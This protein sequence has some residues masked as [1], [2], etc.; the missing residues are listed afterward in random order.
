MQDSPKNFIFIGRS[1]CGKGTQAELLIN[2]LKENDSPDRGIFYMEIGK[3]FRDYLNEQTYTTGLS[4]E[5]YKKG[6]LQPD[7]LAIH[8]W[9]HSII[10]DYNGSDHMIVD[11]IPRSL[12][13][14]EVFETAMNFYDK[15]EVFVIN[16]DVSEDWSRARLE[17]R[18]RADD[19][20]K[21]EV[22]NRLAWF[23][24][25]VIPAIDYFRKNSRY[26]VLDI[27]GEQSIEEVFAEILNK[28]SI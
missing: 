4:K 24:R 10:A 14:A 16:L 12:I 27:N 7:F 9:A 23:T 22:E 11:G 17:A 18:G 2:H 6:E 25:D 15:Q 20:E 13:Q 8:I 21:D 19:K 3:K 1:G 26:K 28:I 5:I